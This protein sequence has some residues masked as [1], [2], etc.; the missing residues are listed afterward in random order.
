MDNTTISQKPK[1]E[2]NMQKVSEKDLN[3]MK[4][5]TIVIIILYNLFS[6]NMGILDEYH[7]TNILFPISMTKMIGS[8]CSMGIF[9]WF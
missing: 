4:G 3:I 6:L 5:I 2:Q 9:M 1:K 8:F 7:C